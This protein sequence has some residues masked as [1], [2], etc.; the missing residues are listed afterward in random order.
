VW[1]E[2][3]YG[4]GLRSAKVVEA[5]PDCEFLELAWK[6]TRICEKIRRTMGGPGKIT[7]ENS[8]GTYLESRS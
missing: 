8:R 1:G 5:D 2:W 6:L 3:P 4:R 7:I